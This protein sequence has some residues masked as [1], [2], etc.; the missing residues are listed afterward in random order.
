MMEFYDAFLYSPNAVNG[1]SI[2]YDLRN[3]RSPSMSMILRVAEWGN[4]P[5]RQAMWQEL[6]VECRVCVSSGMRYTISKAALSAFFYVCPPVCRTYLLT[7][8]DDNLKDAV[9]FLPNSRA[10]TAPED[11]PQRSPED[12]Q[13]AFKQKID[14]EITDEV[15][16]MKDDAAKR[17]SF[18]FEGLMG[19]YEDIMRGDTNR[20]V[21]PANEDPHAWVFTTQSW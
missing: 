11:T 12:L 6:N 1:F 13:A 2:T 10:E 5:T 15:G 16:K 14:S 19:V 9:V 21:T 7:A 3:L 8:P 17:W 20:P 18:D 4:E